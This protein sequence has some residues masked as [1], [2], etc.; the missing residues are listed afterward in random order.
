MVIGRPGPGSRSVH[1]TFRAPE[2]PVVDEPDRTGTRTGGCPVR[3][4]G[5]PRG[6]GPAAIGGTP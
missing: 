1:R 3:W 4:A 2:P 6:H 5:N